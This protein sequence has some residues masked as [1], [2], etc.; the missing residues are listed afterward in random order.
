[1]CPFASYYRNGNLVP[2]VRALSNQRS[3]SVALDNSNED[4]EHGITETVD[5]IWRELGTEG[6]LERSTPQTRRQRCLHSILF[7]SDLSPIRIVNFQNNIYH[8]PDYS[9]IGK[10]PVI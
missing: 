9:T 10:I 3:F 2:R 5:Q 1:M 4:S 6:I 8:K 7:T